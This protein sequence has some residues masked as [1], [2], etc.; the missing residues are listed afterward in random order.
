MATKTRQRATAEA[1]ERS[2]AGGR[3]AA[4]RTQGGVPSAGPK[5]RDAREVRATSEGR[6]GCRVRLKCR[7]LYTKHRRTHDA[8]WVWNARG[9]GGCAGWTES[10]GGGLLQGPGQPGQAHHGKAGFTCAI[11][12]GGYSESIVSSGSTCCVRGGDVLQVRTHTWG[13]VTKGRQRGAHARTPTTPRARSTGVYAASRAT[14]A[15]QR[16]TLAVSS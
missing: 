7:Y 6:D 14:A 9:T 2:E 11:R 15:D 13:L 10:G 16:D 8:A 3:E 12:I 5:A 4:R 1:D